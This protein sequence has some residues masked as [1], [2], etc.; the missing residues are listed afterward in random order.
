MGEKKE[1]KQDLKS[2]ALLILRRLDKKA[3]PKAGRTEGSW[4]CRGEF[5]TGRK[6]FLR[7]RKSSKGNRG[8]TRKP[9]G[10]DKHSMFPLTHRI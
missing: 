3:K 2:I 8:R 6:G 4:K 7:A 1:E 5:K 9:G 10:K